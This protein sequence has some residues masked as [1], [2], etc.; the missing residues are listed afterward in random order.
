MKFAYGIES[1]F[2]GTGRVLLDPREIIKSTKGRFYRLSGGAKIQEAWKLRGELEKGY[3]TTRRQA[4]TEIKNG[5]TAKARLM[6]AQ[7]NMEAEKVLPDILPH[8][9]EDWKERRRVKLESTFQARDIQNLFQKA[10]EQ[11]REEI[12]GEL[13]PKAVKIIEEYRSKK[14]GKP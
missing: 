5:N 4:I 11:L 9:A 8:L 10:R 12:T 2:A 7:W 3:Y 13:N 14:Y 1:M 6:I